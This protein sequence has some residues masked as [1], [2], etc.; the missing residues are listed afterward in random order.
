M[1]DDMVPTDVMVHA[2]LAQLE[3]E[4][5]AL[6]ESQ[7]VF[8]TALNRAFGYTVGGPTA[9]VEFLS[10]V[11]DVL[12]ERDALR[13]DLAALKADPPCDEETHE[14]IFD[15]GWQAARR[16]APAEYQETEHELRHSAYLAWS[17]KEGA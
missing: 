4:N 9:P 11:A 13:A 3:A 15:A 12:A 14:Y 8:C 1:T 6:R 16:T 10:E 2:R 5:A 17:A 7:S